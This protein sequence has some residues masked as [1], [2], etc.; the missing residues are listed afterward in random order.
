ME[1]MNK[2]IGEYKVR[3]FGLTKIVIIPKEL[4]FQVGDT[5]IIKSN[6]SGIIASLEKNLQ[7][8]RGA[9]ENWTM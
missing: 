7:I 3:Q 9:M 8:I 4:D 1:S 5:I 2:F 6:I